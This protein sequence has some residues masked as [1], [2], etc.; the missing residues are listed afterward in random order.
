MVRL[1]YLMQTVR[2]ATFIM[3]PALYLGFPSGSH[4]HVG[5][6]LHSRGWMVATTLASRH[7]GQPMA[8]IHTSTYRRE[9]SLPIPGFCVTYCAHSARARWGKSKRSVTCPAVYFFGGSTAV[10]TCPRSH[11]AVRCCAS[12]LQSPNSRF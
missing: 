1:W 11:R 6:P 4:F 7:R 2:L 5:T 3:G 8:G 10:G 9:V 12:A